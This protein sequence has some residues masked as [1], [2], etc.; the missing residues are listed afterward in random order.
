MSVKTDSGTPIGLKRLDR[1]GQATFDLSVATP[2]DLICAKLR[3][4]RD[5][6]PASERLPEVQA[7]KAQFVQL[8][9]GD[10]SEFR[11]LAC[12]YFR[13]DDLLAIN[14]RLIGEGRI[15][16]K[17]AGML[18]ARRILSHHSDDP[19][20]NLHADVSA[21]LEDHDSF[22]IGSDVFSEFLADNDLLQLRAELMGDLRFSHE[23]FAKVE[24]RFVEGKFSPSIVA[25]FRAMLD[26]YGQAPIIARSSS[27]LEDSF[28]NAFAGKYRSEFCANQGSPEH[29]LGAFLRAV[30]LIYA[31]TLNPDVLAYRRKWGLMECDEQM[32]I[33]VQ[34]VSGQRHRRFFFPTLAGVALSHNHYVWANRIDPTQGVIRLV[35]GLGT[36]AVDRVGSDYPRMIPISHPQLRPEIGA[37][38]AKYAQRHVDVLDLADNAFTSLPLD[39]VITDGAYP[40][41]YLLISELRDG[42]V[43]DP[44]SCLLRDGSTQG[45]VMTFNNLIQ[46]TNFVKLL[47]DMLARLEE[48]YGCPVE[49]EFTATLAEDGH[50]RINLL[51]CRPMH[52]VGASSSV[53]L[54]DKIQPDRLLFRSSRF[55]GCGVVDCVRYLVY[56]DPERYARMPSLEMKRTVR[57]VIGKI[58][59]RLR[60]VGERMVLL[61]PG[62]FGSSNLNLGINVR[63]AD[64]DNAAVLVEIGREGSDQ[65]PDVSYGTHFFQDLVESHMLY[66]AISPHANGQG[67]DQNAVLN[68]AFFEA[69]PNNLTNLV[70][71]AK[72]FETLIKVIDVAQEDQTLNVVADLRSHRAV[73]FLSSEP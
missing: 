17:A 7:L 41:L 37:A 32:A 60:D 49:T 61:G 40:H 43:Y 13:L 39:E 23:D 35:F 70:P 71:E 24:A 63:Y 10:Q 51:Q 72:P 34:R 31:S 57:S 53:E 54:P 50:I 52:A 20:E 58:N 16:G 59:A 3:Y 55:M 68:R 42:G 33:L 1:V 65:A 46:R 67:E 73:G 69:C 30:K 29:R 8:V 12:R 66:L 6:D 48:A 45:C 38:V 14:D 44:I 62:R 22:Y 56:I 15:G 2:R 4:Y 36:R 19:D 18:L 64:I 47:G 28:S 21:A 11:Q 27:L 5:T 9:L 25:Q 26:H